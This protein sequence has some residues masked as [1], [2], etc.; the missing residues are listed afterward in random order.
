MR[1]KFE[2][3]VIQL[4]KSEEVLY[5]NYS[6]EPEKSFTKFKHRHPRLRESQLNVEL[7][8]GYGGYRNSRQA[9][10]GARQ[11]IRGLEK[12][13]YEVIAGGPLLLPYWQTYVIEIEGNPSHVYVGE[14]NYERE[15]RLQQHIYHFNSARE[16]KKYDV[17]S[18]A[19]ILCDGQKYRSKQASLAAEAALA[20][21]LKQQGYKV[22]GGH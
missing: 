22:E 19:E 20:E 2:V 11:L 3:Y 18:L 13:G 4:G 10:R 8:D 9:E 7:A 17:L 14:T 5:V 16:L 15:K 6:L 21:K 1:A 12:R